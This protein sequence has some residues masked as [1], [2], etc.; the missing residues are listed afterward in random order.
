[1]TSAILIIV[2]PARGSSEKPTI[3]IQVL[4]FI[5]S[6]LYKTEECEVSP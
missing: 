4:K 2:L 6:R 1:M 5:F 3:D